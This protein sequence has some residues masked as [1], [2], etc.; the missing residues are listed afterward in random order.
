[1][2]QLFLVI[3]IL[4]GSVAKA[5]FFEK[6]AIY[7]SNSGLIGNYF[8]LSSSLNFIHKENFMVEVGVMGLAKRAMDQPADY[9]GGLLSAFTLGI[10]PRNFVIS[11]QLLFGKSIN[12]TPKG[13]QR[14]NLKAGPTWSS[15]Q[16]PHNWQRV[17]GLG[18]IA[19]NYSYE[20]LDGSGLGLIIRP[21]FEMPFTQLYGI[22]LGTYFHFHRH[23][24]NLGIELSVIMGSL[25]K[26]R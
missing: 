24:V 26:K 3:F 18:L 13:D 17:S 19:G 2:K 23:S 7:L 12:L 10:A 16:R 20:Y 11:Y 25:R 9:S 22:G 21:T 8:G 14:I 5:Q 6:N 4:F 1:M 15:T